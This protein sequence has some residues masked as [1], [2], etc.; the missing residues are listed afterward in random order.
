MFSAWKSKIGNNWDTQYLRLRDQIRTAHGYPTRPDR[1]APMVAFRNFVRFIIDSDDP[2][3]V[4]DAHWD[5]QVNVLLYDLIPYDMV[6]RFERFAEDFTTI[7][8]RLGAPPPVLAMAREV[9]NP[10]PQVSLAAAYDQ[11]LADLVYRYFE[12]DF[13]TFG[14]DRGGWLYDGT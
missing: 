8:T 7:L 9:T 3:V 14:Y 11:E 4:R 5:L 10:T 6:G 1:P 12:P 2:N 13:E